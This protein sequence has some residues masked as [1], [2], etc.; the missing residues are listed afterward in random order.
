[1]NERDESMN[2]SINDKR[3]KENGFVSRTWDVHFS[4][5]PLWGGGFGFFLQRRRQ[6]LDPS[7]KFIKGTDKK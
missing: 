5:A 6:N 7:K 4:S 3:E 2:Q 1:M